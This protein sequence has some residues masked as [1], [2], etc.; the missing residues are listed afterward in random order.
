M[1][2]LPAADAR[3]TRPVA[4]NA[5]TQ[6][7]TPGAAGR[8]INTAGPRRAT[9]APTQAPRNTHTVAPRIRALTQRHT[10]THTHTDANTRARAHK[11]VRVYPSTPRVPPEYPSTEHPSSAPIVCNRA[12]AYPTE[13]APKCRRW[14]PMEVAVEPPT[15]PYR[16]PSAP[17]LP[18]STPKYPLEYPWRAPTTTPQYP[19]VPR[20]AAATPSAPPSTP[21]ST[22][23]VPL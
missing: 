14:G 21:P 22:S 6:P 5:T 7:R 15:D 17:Q 8:A 4:P 2:V 12:A 23:Q 11:C 9:T 1:K 13:T 19:T 20:H 3:K 18:R 16:S 10:H